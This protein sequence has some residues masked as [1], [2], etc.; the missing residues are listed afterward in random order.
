MR[1]TLPLKRNNRPLQVLICCLVLA[2]V[3]KAQQT[4]VS[5]YNVYTGFTDLDSPSYGLNQTGFHLQAGARLR[6]WISTGFDYTVASG[7]EHLTQAKLT[8]AVQQQL[9]PILLA[10]IRQGLIP[11]SYQLSVP[12]DV[13]T[14]TFTIGGEYMNRHFEKMTLFVR[15]SVAALREVATPH[16]TDAVSTLIVQ[17]LTP[18]GHELDWVGA[19]GAGGGADYIFARHLAL[20]TQLDVIYEHP[21]SDILLDGRWTLRYSIG[22]SFNFGR[23]IL[24]NS[25]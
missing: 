11:P 18:S 14:Q 20:R 10:F 19:Y 12:T 15:P 17:G 1:S 7:S 5:R 23:N 8:P 16:P 21:F 25:H 24:A 22:P 4:Y 9:A 2:S 3:C 13:F 6:K